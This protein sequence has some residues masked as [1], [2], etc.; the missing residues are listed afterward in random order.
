MQLPWRKWRAFALREGRLVSGGG[1]GRQ[2]RQYRQYRQRQWAGRRRLG[3]RPPTGYV[4]VAVGRSASN[5]RFCA[6]SRGGSTSPWALRRGRRGSDGRSRSRQRRRGLEGFGGCGRDRS[7][8][9]TVGDLDGY[10][11]FL[12]ISP[13]EGE[14]THGHPPPTRLWRV[15]SL[16]LSQGER[17]LGMPSPTVTFDPRCLGSGR[18]QG[19]PLR[20]R[21]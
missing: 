8:Q 11:R 2:Y 12:Q 18:R 13:A 10:G 17:G 16:S 5:W 7:P 21:G 15:P 9:P 19:P 3:V 6:S 4:P 14:T 1:H 20:G